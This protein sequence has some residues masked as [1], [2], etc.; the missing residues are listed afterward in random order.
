M[1]LDLTLQYESQNGLLLTPAEVL[2]LYLYGLPLCL[3]DGRELSYDLI[4]QKIF[5]AQNEIENFLQIKLFPQIRRE[6]ANFH[7]NEFKSWGFLKTNYPVVAPMLLEGF[8]GNS[9]QVEYPSS[10]VNT[11]QEF[12]TRQDFGTDFTNYRTIHL[13]PAKDAT[14]VYADVAIFYQGVLPYTGYYGVQGIPNYWFISYLTG[15]EVVPSVLIDLVGKYVA[16]QLL[17]ILGDIMYQVGASS[18]SISLDGLSQNISLVRN[19]RD[20]LFGA[21]INLYQTEITDTLKILRG[22][23]KDISFDVV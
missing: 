18:N 15:F 6:T 23:Y 13:I 12:S 19:A 9:K 20:G 1:E 8:I 11:K 3:S 16:I 4:K 5:V 2:E 17:A 7:R 14:G 21:R 10:W 22:R